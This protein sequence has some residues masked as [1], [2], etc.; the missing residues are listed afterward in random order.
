M[1]R[2]ATYH[3]VA[4]LLLLSIA[5]G[6]TRAAEPETC[7]TPKPTRDIAG[8]FRARM[9][10]RPT[11]PI[12]GIWQLTG[13]GIVAIT[14]NDDESGL[15][16]VSIDC[17]DRSVLPGTVIGN[18]RQSAIAEK[19]EA[20]LFTGFSNGHP[21]SSKKIIV[22]LNDSSHLSFISVKRG[23]KINLFRLIP[24]MFRG[25]I[26]PAESRADDMQG[27]VRLDRPVNG[28]SAKP[29]YL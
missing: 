1:R 23:V 8:E 9:L 3:I 5:G 12:E 7:P 29:R 4:L 22:R 15:A 6:H 26:T 10:T 17:P 18:L 25:V 27:A 14:K 28:R 19:Y 13:G 21:T 24:Y 11:L 2:C 20:V 16:I